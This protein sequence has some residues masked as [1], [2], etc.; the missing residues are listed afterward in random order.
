MSLLDE[1][2]ADK[3]KK[4]TG[5]TQRKSLLQEYVDDNG[6]GNLN[7]KYTNKSLA[8]GG[9]FG[10]TAI[11][12]ESSRNVDNKYVSSFFSDAKDYFKIVQSDLDIA[13]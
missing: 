6:Y 4:E 12:T 8:N 1:Y 11:G 2:K 13:G 7:V 10:A 9:G 5:S 3:K